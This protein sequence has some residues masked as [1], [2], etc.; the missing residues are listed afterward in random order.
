LPRDPLREDHGI[1]PGL[2]RARRRDRLDQLNR[3][4]IPAIDAT[5]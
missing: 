3:S 5:P 2:A 1:V 4:A